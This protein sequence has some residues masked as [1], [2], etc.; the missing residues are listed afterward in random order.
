MRS[1]ATIFAA[2]LPLSFVVVM[3]VIGLLVAN[4]LQSPQRRSAPVSLLGLVEE[5]VPTLHP[6]P[7]TAAPTHAFTCDLSTGYGVYQKQPRIRNESAALYYLYDYRYGLM[8]N[9]IQ[10]LFA[11]LE[12]TTRDGVHRLALGKVYTSFLRALDIQLLLDYSRVTFYLNC[13]TLAHAARAVSAHARHSDR[14]NASYVNCKDSTALGFVGPALMFVTK[15]IMPV[16]AYERSRIAV[17]GFSHL[18]AHGM[19][20]FK[21]LRDTA[22]RALDMLRVPPGNGFV[23]GIHR[24]NHENV[25]EDKLRNKRLWEWYV[26]DGSKDASALVTY[27]CKMRRLRSHPDCRVHP[28]VPKGSNC[29][30]TLNEAQTDYLLDAWP[31]LRAAA[32]TG[33]VTLF[34]ATDSKDA[35]GDVALMRDHSRRVG[36][37]RSVML[38]QASGACFSAHD[39]RQSITMLMEMWALTLADVH[40]GSVASTC[41]DLV[42]HWR[43]GIGKANHS[44]LPDQCYGGWYEQKVVPVAQR[45]PKTVSG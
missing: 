14:L 8:C 33:Q 42:A 36:I 26:C 9:G 18:I 39:K 1:G 4:S 17:M 23:L 41:D 5:A 12:E 6:T 28:D 44:T 24:R 31:A 43:I 32:A 7:M 45:R 20:P 19:R 25:C 35:A 27:T 11:M 22:Q 15:E 38:A 21:G 16:P 37:S 10:I 13:G 34:T 3:V 30:I 29:N 40:W 2:A